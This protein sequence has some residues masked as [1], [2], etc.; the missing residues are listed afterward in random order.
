M[1]LYPLLLYINYNNTKKKQQYIIFLILLK[2]SGIQ[3][4][5]KYLNSYKIMT[6]TSKT[7]MIDTM[8]LHF[9]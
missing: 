9:L 6:K 1:L 3:L 7:Y 2:I 4:N 5:L 8:T